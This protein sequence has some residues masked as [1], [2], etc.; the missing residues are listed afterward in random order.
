MGNCATPPRSFN[1]VK[2][3][4]RE[5]RRKRHET[6]R[7]VL[8]SIFLV[9]IAIL[10]SLFV[11]IIC[12]IVDALDG[13]VPEQPDDTEETSDDAG[14]AGGVLYDGATTKANSDIHTG[15]L[16]IVNK[17]NYFDPSKAANL[18]NIY[19]NRL[20]YNGINN[21]YQIGESTWKLNSDALNAFNQ[22]MY[23]YYELEGDG[24]VKISSAYR[25][26]EDQANSATSST[27]PGY[28]DHHTG[29]CLALRTTAGGYLE[30][31]HWIYQNAH[32]YGYIVRY[33]ADK[34][35]WT[36]VSGYEYC[37]RYVGVAHATYIKENGLCLEEYVDM[38][39]NDYTSEHLKINGADGNEYEVYYVPVSSGDLTTVKI[40]SNYQY[41]VSGDNIGGFIVTVNLTAPNA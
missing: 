12:S 34:T 37:I 35:A 23:K 39:K 13:N 8:L 31:D 18:K 17:D 7:M 21:T 29:Y 2:Q 38:L 33:P 32:K 5:Q 30:S 20:K 40:P 28:S 27:L 11:F 1:T 24:S 4:N 9:G 26:Y 36:G 14:T 15:E 25:S 22:M 3:S 41:T 10:L 16:V 6:G 19:D